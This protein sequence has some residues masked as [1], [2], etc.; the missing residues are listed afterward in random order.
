MD[1]EALRREFNRLSFEINCITDDMS[2]GG[3][4][5]SQ[6]QAALRSQLAKVQERLHLMDTE[7]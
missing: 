6:R 5:Q 7:R 1:D 2:M 4:D 3:P